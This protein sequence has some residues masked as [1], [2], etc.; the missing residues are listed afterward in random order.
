[1]ARKETGSRDYQRGKVYG[2]EREITAWTTSRQSD[3]VWGTHTRLVCDLLPDERMLSVS[4]CQLLVERVCKDYGLYH[5][6]VLIFVGQG[7]H[8]WANQFTISLPPWAQR[9]SIVLH[10]VCHVLFCPDLDKILHGRV[11]VRQYIELWA[12]YLGAD[13]STLL[14]SARAHRLNVGKPEELLQPL[15]RRRRISL[16]LKEDE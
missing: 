12:A 14:R 5:K 11:F 16:W 1:M 8:A 15:R 9:G 10:E 6:P 4:E 7:R 2:W 13:R 3:D